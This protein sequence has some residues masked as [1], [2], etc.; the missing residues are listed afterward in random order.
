MAKYSMNIDGIIASSIAKWKI[1]INRG[2]SQFKSTARILS[3][4]DTWDFESWHR[5]IPAVVEWNVIIGKIRNDVKH[6]V[7]LE[8]SR[9]TK[10]YY[11]GKRSYKNR[12]RKLIYTWKG[13]QTY[14]RTGNIEKE[15]IRNLLIQALK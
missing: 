12:G 9:K 11:K 2:T 4:R 15:N 1:W 14:Q 7:Y 8:N 13:N 3:P 10:N 6:W 5:T